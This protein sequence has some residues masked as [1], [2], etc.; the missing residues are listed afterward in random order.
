MLLFRCPALD[1]GPEACGA[2]KRVF[3]LGRVED[4]QI[5]RATISA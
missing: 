5:A 1:S 3:F 2:E 4:L